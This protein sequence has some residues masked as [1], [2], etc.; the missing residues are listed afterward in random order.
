MRRIQQLAASFP[1]LARRPATYEPWDA[2]A[3]ARAWAAGSGG[4]LD[5][6]L[7]VL[8]VW[9][10]EMD[11]SVF[12]LQRKGSG[13]FNMHTALGNWDRAHR[14]AFLYWAEAPWWP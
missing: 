2:E 3:F 11:W 4:E 1:T 13:R 9:D 7:F 5:A 12:G 14:Q 6:A 10:P 8:S